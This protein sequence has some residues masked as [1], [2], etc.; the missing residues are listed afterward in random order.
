MMQ[1]ETTIPDKVVDQGSI[2]SRHKEGDFLSFLGPTC[3]TMGP[4]N[5][6]QGWGGLGTH[7]VPSSQPHGVTPAPFKGGRVGPTAAQVGSPPPPP[8][9]AAMVGSPP[10]PPQTAAMVGSPPPPP[11]TAAMVGSP[12]P[13]PQTAAMVGA[14]STS[15]CCSL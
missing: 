15:D 8:Q 3:C 5:Q 9:T 2:S 13:P 1:Q 10:P 7:G 12:P 4:A 11:Q 14:T 6:L